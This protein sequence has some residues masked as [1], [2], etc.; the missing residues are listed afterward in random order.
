MEKTT[1]LST[2][3]AQTYNMS[4]LAKQAAR[5]LAANKQHTDLDEMGYVSL[6][7][8]VNTMTYSPISTMYRN[9]VQANLL[10]VVYPFS[11]S[12]GS[13]KDIPEVLTIDD[14]LIDGLHVPTSVPSNMQKV[15]VNLTPMISYNMKDRND[16]VR[17]SDIPKTVSTIVKA[18]LCTSY[19]DSEEWL[20]LKISDFIIE[21]Y[22]MAMSSV[23]IRAFNLDYEESHLIKLLFAWHYAALLDSPKSKDDV[24]KLLIRNRKLFKGMSGQDQMDEIFAR[25]N[26]VKNG[27][28]MSISIITEVIK[29]H[30]PSRMNRIRTGDIY[31]MFALSSADNTSM[32]IA[33]DYPPYFLHQVLNTVSGSK[34]PILNNVLNTKMNRMNV[35]KIIDTVIRSREIFEGAQR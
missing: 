31:R 22:T 26:E 8:N 5:F 7:R 4:L 28:P 3:F 12:K 30:G 21:F 24:P 10:D 11:F 6:L 2:P 20:P 13:V 25:I 15:W 27:R 32:M 23:L 29:A 35:N 1:L 18:I 16:P 19:N 17:I 9:I 34:H 14:V 33:A